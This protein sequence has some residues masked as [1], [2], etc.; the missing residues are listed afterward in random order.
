MKDDYRELILKSLKYYLETVD[1]E[2][3]FYVNHIS[4]F[5][6][7][8][9]EIKEDAELIGLSV[10]LEKKSQEF[11]DS[12]FEWQDQLREEGQKY[13]DHMESVR[14]LCI[15]LFYKDSEFS[16]DMSKYQVLVEENRDVLEKHGA[17]K[18]LSK[19]VSEKTAIDKI[20]NKVK[21]SFPSERE[22]PNADDI[23]K[24]F[25]T[26][27]QEIYRLADKYVAPKIEEIKRQEQATL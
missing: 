25:P 17:Y 23:R 21:A 6:K 14:Q 24:I 15:K 27:V 2:N 4:I 7:Q 26:E 22:L 11:L 19:Y 5:V 12:E 20:Y 1:H 3:D 16:I 10:L 18:N 8:L 9:A 13:H